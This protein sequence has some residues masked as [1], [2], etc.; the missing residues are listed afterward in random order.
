MARGF[1]VFNIRGAAQTP[2]SRLPM[3]STSEPVTSDQPQRMPPLPPTGSTAPRPRA[4][5]RTGPC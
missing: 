1:R 5:C 4:S 3:M 2:R